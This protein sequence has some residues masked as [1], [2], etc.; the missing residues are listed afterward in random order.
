MLLTTCRIITSTPNV[1]SIITYGHP[2]QSAVNTKVVSNL[3]ERGG[4]LKYRKRP[5]KT[6]GAAFKQPPMKTKRLILEALLSTKTYSVNQLRQVTQRPPFTQKRIS[7]PAPQSNKSDHEFPF[8]KR[9]EHN[10]LWG[11]R[12]FPFQPADSRHCKQWS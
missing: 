6:K 9:F 4:L 1:D 7:D 5:Q 12:P 3:G 8:L 11:E 10:L 2:V